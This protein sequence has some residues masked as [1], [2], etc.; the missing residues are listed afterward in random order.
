MS[1][2]QLDA[3]KTVTWRRASQVYPDAVMF[4]DSGVT[5][6]DIEQGFLGNGYLL[7]V[8]AVMSDAQY[9]GQIY[10]LFETK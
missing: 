8:L 5:P 6:S 3:Y 9:A 2:D 7:T 1:Y 4:K 10:D